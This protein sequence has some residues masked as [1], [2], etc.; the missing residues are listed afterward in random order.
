MAARRQHEETLALIEAS[1]EAGLAPE[2]AP[3][4]YTPDD[5]AVTAD[6][7]VSKSL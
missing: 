1:A 4:V 5:A 3:A 6:A 2:A 7:E